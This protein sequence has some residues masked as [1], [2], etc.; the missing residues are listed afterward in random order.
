MSR[1]GHPTALFHVELLG[2]SVPVLNEDLELALKGPLNDLSH[3]WNQTFRAGP[4][5]KRNSGRI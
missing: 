5:S 3:S 4:S 1:I 2:R